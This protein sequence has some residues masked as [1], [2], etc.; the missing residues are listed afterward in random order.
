MFTICVQL[1]GYTI[2]VW[3]IWYSRIGG[4]H[5]PAVKSIFSEEYAE[6]IRRLKNART[7]CGMSQEAVCRRLDRPQNFLSKIESCQ[8]RLDVLE[9]LILGKVYG[10]PLSYF[11]DDLKV[12]LPLVQY[13]A[14]DES[15]DGNNEGH[16][17]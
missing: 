5:C 6:I 17:P 11:T 14:E 7:E 4:I 9:L 15:A 10:K 2:S 12:E 1:A 13:G 16:T 3:S 8:R